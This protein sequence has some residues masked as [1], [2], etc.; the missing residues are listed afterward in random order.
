MLLSRESVELRVQDQERIRSQY[1]GLLYDFPR[2]RTNSRYYFLNLFF[3][4]NHVTDTGGRSVLCE[5][6]SPKAHV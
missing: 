2:L 5:R 3:S 1:E 4:C 6:S